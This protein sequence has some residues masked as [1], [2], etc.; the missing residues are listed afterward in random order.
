MKHILIDLDHM[1]ILKVVDGKDA[2]KRCMYWADILIPKNE[3]YICGNETKDLQS[4]TYEELILL[5]NNSSKRVMG[6]QKNE[7]DMRFLLKDI[8]EDFE[9]DSTSL[10]D[11]VK[12]LGKPLKEQSV[13]PQPESKADKA[14]NKKVSSI[15]VRPKAGSLTVRAWEAADYYFTQVIPNDVDS[16]E[17]RDQVIKACTENGVNPS[18][19]STQFAKWKKHHNMT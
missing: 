9:V 6:R 18:T 5:F 15:P 10:S 1:K 17:F 4:F 14:A 16:K 13:L 3:Y 11:L 12:K 7:K 8:I 19:A 2:L